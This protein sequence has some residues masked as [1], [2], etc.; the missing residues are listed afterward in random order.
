[1]ELCKL[2]YPPFNFERTGCKG[3]PY[4][5]KLKSQLE[6]MKELLPDEYKQCQMI[7]GKVYKEYEKL[8][9]RLTLN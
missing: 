8:N 3:C 9:Y 5:L 2:Y 7:W 1:M 6:V 4:N